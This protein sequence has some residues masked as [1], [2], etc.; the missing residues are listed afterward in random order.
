MQDT[1][2][3]LLLK[4]GYVESK[5]LLAAFVHTSSIGTKKVEGYPV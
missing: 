5:S 3:I 2:C 1:M 4:D